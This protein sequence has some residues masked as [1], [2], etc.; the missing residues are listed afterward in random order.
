MSS[1][2]P[3]RRFLVAAAAAGFALLLAEFALRLLPAPQPLGRLSYQTATGE[4]VADLAAAVAHGFVVPVAP[5]L[6]P[7]PRFMF[8]PGL[9][10]Y[11]CYSDAERLQRPWFDAQGRVPVHINAAGI[12]DRDDLGPDKPAGQRRIVCIG[13]SFTFAW[14]VRDAD[15]WPRRLE[16]ALR[17]DGQDV[18]TVNCG[19]AGALCVDEYEYG[20][21]HRFGAFQP[22]LVVVTLCL[23]DLIPSSGLC[24]A[25]PP[26][27]TGIRLLDRLRA[28]WGR[29]PLDLDPARDWVGELLA[30]GRE[31][32]EA[33]GYYG[34][35]APFEAM[36]SQGVPQASLRRMQTW[37]SQHGCKLLVVLW[38]FLQG[39]GPGRHYPFA[40]LHELV[41]ADCAAAGLPLLDLLPTLRHTP[42]EQLWVTPADMHANPLAH[43]LATPALVAFVRSHWQP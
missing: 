34:T 35:D 20:L 26:P 10:F 30:L 12:R 42:Q 25:A 36:W 27:T 43:E 39:L 28:N 4:P 1:G 21:R 8:R 3:F 7:R 29:G 5:N 9:D 31:A 23:N 11:L 19:A 41:A 2:R 18:R 16:Q 14:G 6:A 13:D 24:L 37:C 33:G 32:G 15:G 38:P 40:R 22:D 17:Q